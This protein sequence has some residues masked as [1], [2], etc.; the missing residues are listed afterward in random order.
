MKNLEDLRGIWRGRTVACIASG[1]SL[2]AEDCELVHA[3]GLPTIVVNTSFRRAPWADILFAMDAGWWVQHMAEV[4]RDF[5]GA[6]WGYVYHPGVIATKGKLFPMGVGNSGSFAISM[7]VVTKP[8]RIL[9][10]GYD[11]QFAPDGRRHWHE[12]HPGN[13]GN[14]VSI[15]RWPYQFDLVSRYAA[16]HGIKVVNCSRSTA[17]TCFERGDL[18][19][20]LARAVPEAAAA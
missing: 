8:M 15:K 10:L 11:C 16:S 5:A 7:A 17:L 12:D 1:P 3:A 19:A 4:E 6:R 9:L 13:L 20:E 14:A 18:E 2:T